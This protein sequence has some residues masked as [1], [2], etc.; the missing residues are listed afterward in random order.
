MNA[1]LLRPSR[2]GFFHQACACGALAATGAWPLSAWTAEGARTTL[3]AHQALA[4]LKQGNDDFLANRL[5]PDPPDHARRRLEL[6]RSQTPFAVLVGCSDSRVPPELL[7]GAGL[8]ELFI[9]RNAGNTVDTVALGSIQYGVNVL[10][11]PLIVVLGHERCGAVDAA[12]SVVQKNAVYPG[13]IGQMIEPIIPA[14]L[15]ARSGG[16]KEDELLDQAVRENIRRTVMRLR[17][18]EPSLIEPQRAG[19]L[20]I[21]GAR[22]D[23]DDGKVDFIVE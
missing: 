6:A 12:V 14:V 13:S 5:P 8:G 16:A 7:F 4:R 3:T 11:A 21:V 9:V 18:S 19:H 23:L 15:K 1:P 10:G 22:Y 20:R 17:E 2:R